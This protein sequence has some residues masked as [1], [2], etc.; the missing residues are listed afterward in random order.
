MKMLMTADTL[1]QTP[2]HPGTSGRKKHTCEHYIQYVDIY[3]TK[4]YSE[5]LRWACNECYK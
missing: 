4:L 2:S 3:L 1:A 5:S